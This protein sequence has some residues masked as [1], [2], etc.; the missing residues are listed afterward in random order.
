MSLPKVHVTQYTAKIPSSGIQVEYRPYQ[1]K[2]ERALLIAAESK[3]EKQVI[4]AMKNTL[5]NC[6]LTEGIN[7]DTMPI[8]DIQY[9][10]LKLRAKSVGE[11]VSPALECENCKGKIKCNINIDEIDVTFTEGHSDEVTLKN[12]NDIIGLK[13]IYPTIDVSEKIKDDATGFN[14]VVNSISEIWDSKNKWTINKDFTIKELSEMIN[15]LNQNQYQEILKF[16][17]TMP[18]L[19]HTIKD[20][21]CPS[22]HTV[23]S[24]GIEGLESFFD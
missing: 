21:E 15:S 3:E 7:Y 24:Y 12:G 20:L 22:C 16:F 6:I 17:E 2:E 9:L 5:K 4:T 13:M 1:V 11:T 14:L 19:K 10:F 23:K 18:R 8:F